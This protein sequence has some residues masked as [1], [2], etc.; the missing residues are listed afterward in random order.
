MFGLW[1]LTMQGGS[2]DYLAKQNKTF[3]DFPLKN[4]I[5]SLALIAGLSACGGGNPF[6]D[7]TATDAGTG[8][9]VDGG[10]TGDGTPTDT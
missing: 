5:I 2:S 8:D 6:V 7:A 9:A 4:Q 10:I 1:S 3:E